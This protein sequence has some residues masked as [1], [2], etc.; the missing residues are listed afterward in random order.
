MPPSQSET[1]TK[2]PCRA[3]DTERVLRRRYYAVN[4][5][6]MNPLSAWLLARR[7]ARR[8]WRRRAL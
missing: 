8:D 1:R 5:H 3:C 2:A 7:V 6:F 4:K